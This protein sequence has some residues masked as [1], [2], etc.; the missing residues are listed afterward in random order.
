MPEVPADSEPESRDGE[1]ITFYSYDGGSGQTMALANVG[2]ILAA[3]GLRVLA[4]DWDVESPG[5]HHFYYPFL[6]EQKLDGPGIHDLIRRYEWAAPEEEGS[7]ERVAL[8]S[9][10][11]RIQQYTLQVGWEFAHGG[12]LDFLP[13]GYQANDYTSSIASLDWENFFGNLNGGE[14]FDALRTDVKRKYDYVLL[15]SPSGLGDLAD[16]CTMHVPDIVVDCFTLTNRSIEGAATIAKRIRWRESIRI[17][18][19]PMLVDLTDKDRADVGRALAMG[20]FNDLPV[21]LSDQRRRQ[22]WAAVEVPYQASYSYEEMLAVFDDPPGLSASLL[23]SF[24]RLTHE[25]TEGAVSALP[26]MPEPLRNRTKLQFVRKLRLAT[27]R[28]IVE[29]WPEDQAWVEWIADVLLASG[30]EVQ[31]RDL[32]VVTMEGEPDSGSAL[33]VVSTTFVERSKEYKRGRPKLAVYVTDVEPP[34][35]LVAVP[36]AV[37]TNVPESKGTERLRGLLAGQSILADRGVRVRYP[38]NEPVI[39]NIPSRNM[40]FSGRED[41]LLQLR[42]KFRENRTEAVCT[43]V[44]H[45]SAGT[46]ITQI[47]LEYAHRFKSLYDLVWWIDCKQHRSI[48]DSLAEL[49][50]RMVDVLDADRLVSMSIAEASQLALLLLRGKTVHPWLLIFNDADDVDGLIPYLPTDGG[51]VVIT[52]RN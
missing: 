2:W 42:A 52:S 49:V 38:G 51:H 23:A 27:S 47:A 11:S 15:N 10:L 26:A 25:I 14:F 22:Y 30:V 19:V 37:L 43:A 16:I 35:E 21:G 48:E 8:I 1:I 18:P 33:S 50:I 12:C 6:N 40:R 3:N 9:R 45:G 5:L 31:E 46:G 13:S 24:E 17:L 29:F 41:C 20:N 4:S 28:I 44:L 39:C 34:A 36:S 32:A 7:E